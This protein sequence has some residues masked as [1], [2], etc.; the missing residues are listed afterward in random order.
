MAILVHVDFT[1]AEDPLLARVTY[2]LP[3]FFSCDGVPYGPENQYIRFLALRLSEKSIK[4]VSEH[5]KEFLLWRVALGIELV[6]ICDRDVD[7]YIEAQCAHSK[8]PGVGLAWNTVNSRISG[9]HRYLIWCRNRG[10]NINISLEEEG[11]RYFGARVR[12]VVRGHPSR[13]LIQSTKFLLLDVAVNLIAEVTSVSAKR[14]TGLG[15]R[16]SLIAKLMLQCGLRLSEA[17]NFPLNDLPDINHRG[18]STP[19]RVLGK[20]NKARVILVPNRLL[21]DIWGY[22]DMERALWLERMAYK[23]PSTTTPP[24]LFI[25]PIGKPLT[26]NWIEKIFAKASKNLGIDAVPHSLRHTFGT[27]HY[28]Y[29]KDLLALSKIMGHESERTTEKFYVHNAILISHAATYEQLQK[30]ID[31]MCGGIS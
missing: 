16:N 1:S 26:G 28:L 10:H 27:Y 6:D 20:G 7:Y 19:A 18:H 17:V 8:A 9:A 3:Q 11:S 22:V 5:I 12:F 21:A 30:D 2:K 29:N 31:K 13:K 4:T 25:S 24:F 15:V 14:N 23:K